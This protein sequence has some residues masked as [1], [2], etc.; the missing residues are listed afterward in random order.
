MKKTIFATLIVSFVLALMSTSFAQRSSS[1]E[2]RTS[3]TDVSR[4]HFGEASVIADKRGA[5]ITWRMAAE[6]NIV[7]Y[8]V[9]QLDAF[10]TRLVNK[11]MLLGPAARAGADEKGGERYQ[12]FDPLGGRGSSYVIESYGLDGRRIVSKQINSK[13]VRDI[14]QFSGVA[15]E[16]LRA[17][18]TS[19]NR[20]V[21]TSALQ[22]TEE[23]QAA[24]V[25][26]SELP[27]DLATHRWVVSQPG[28]SITVRRDGMFR[29]TREMLEGANFP[30]G[31]DPANWRLFLQGVEHPM[32]IGGNGQYLEFFGRGIDTPETDRRVYYLIADSVP[33]RRIE[34]RF[35]RPIG[36]NI[37]SPSFPMTAERK[38]RSTYLNKIFNGDEE[39]YWGPIVTSAVPVSVPL[40]LTDIDSSSQTS[41]LTV[42]MQ[43]FSLTPHQTL[44]IINGHEVGTVTGTHQDSF[45]ADFDIP[46][47]HLLEGANI[48]EVSSVASSDF[49]LFDSVSVE[50]RRHY[51]ADQDRLTF[52]TPGFRR[53]EVDGFSTSNVRVFDITYD[54]HPQL[55]ANAQI[56]DGGGTFTAKLPS[57]RP[58]IYHATE[59]AALLSPAAVA[60][61]F[62]SSLSTPQ[63]AAELVIISH[64]SPAFM[65]ASEAWADYR[66][67]QGFT[68]KVVDV[69]D[70]LDEFNF[71]L[72][73]AAGI[74]SFLKYAY[75]NW[76][77]PPEYVL[78]MG[79]ASYDHRNY[80]AFGYWDLVPT[81]I[82]A[83]VFEETGSDEAL[84]DFNDDGLAEM[85]IGR[86]PARDAAEITIA[87]NKTMAFESDTT[88]YDRGALFAYDLPDPNNFAG[89]SQTLRNQ[90]PQSMA[91]AMVDRGAPNSQNT[92]IG[93]LNTGK[94][95]A[96]YAGHGSSGLWAVATFFG[97]NNVPQL[98]NSDKHT[99]FTMLS[100]LNGYFIRPNS[101]SL[102]ERL[103]KAS[104]GGA[105]VTWSSSGSTTSDIQLLMGTRFFSQLAAGDIDRMGDLIRDAKA[106]IPAGADVRF[107]WVLLG[108]P[109]LKM[110]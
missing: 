40:T 62:P 59:D 17:A 52:F 49:T 68:V 92:L 66:R 85:S 19:K 77:E 42:K 10:G 38:E 86:I 8:Y 14:E 45:S 46:T 2:K 41:T 79:D 93:E 33:G 106:V 108:D 80:E 34:S 90:L 100:C 109:M 88:R 76:Q 3:R 54:G 9:Y 60:E 89:M 6:P 1:I 47:S 16:Q 7:G 48:L 78:L 56:V 57:A 103:L 18:S 44:V 64:S 20:I 94:Y 28:A 43:G 36:G 72:H 35:L 71:G 67:G 21:E 98:T 99:I 24:V 37:T 105:V 82:V 95:I 51:R 50:Y 53:A 29:V 11:S 84:G 13:Y 12:I 101:D 75:E 27:T 58:A 87:L 15:V 55:I 110:R 61:N 73:G 97:L 96:N 70:V 25:A 81:K 83:T 74:K 102:A 91:A 23:L 39:N 26:D 107:S 65:A 31:S 32:I 22:L 69:R 5:L 63:N 30:V 4:A 104:N